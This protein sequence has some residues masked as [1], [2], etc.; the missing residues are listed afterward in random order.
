MFSNKVKAMDAS[1]RWHDGHGMESGLLGSSLK[2]PKAALDIH[3]PTAS[4][5]E[6]HLYQHGDSKQPRGNIHS[7]IA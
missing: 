1:L 5:R 2:S 4:K 6:D 7:V 3:S